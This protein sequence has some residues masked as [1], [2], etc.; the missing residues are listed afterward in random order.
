[1]QKVNL[2]RYD[3]ED[4]SVTVTPIQRNPTD[5]VYKMR[6][7]ADEG[8]ILTDGEYKTPCIDCTL[9]DVDRWYE[10]NDPNEPIAEEEVNYNE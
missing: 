6:L 7:I 1:M 9:E 2:Y 10:I 5:P 3:N 4:G 8:K